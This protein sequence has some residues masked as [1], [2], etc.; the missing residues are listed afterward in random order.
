M[1]ALPLRSKFDALQQ[2][3][4]YGLNTNTA[5]NDPV[6]RQEI[7]EMGACVTAVAPRRRGA[8]SLELAGF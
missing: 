5:E 2:S 8:D 3:M 4:L 1:A 6:G 7:A